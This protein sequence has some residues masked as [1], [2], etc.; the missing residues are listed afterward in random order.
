MIENI[1]RVQDRLQYP[2]SEDGK[3]LLKLVPPSALLVLASVV[4]LADPAKAEVIAQ[5][6]INT[7]DIT[8]IQ[9]IAR[10]VAIPVFTTAGLLAIA[11]FLQECRNRVRYGNYLTVSKVA[12][13]RNCFAYTLFP[14]LVDQKFFGE[15]HFKG[16]WHFRF[17][18]DENEHTV[19]RAAFHDFYKLAKAVENDDPKLLGLN[20]FVALSSMVNPLL[21]RFGFKV[22]YFRDQIGL[23]ALGQE[24]Q[25]Q[26]KLKM[27][28][29][30]ACVIDKK[31]LVQNKEKLAKAAHLP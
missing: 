9:K 11:L 12:P 16:K 26:L 31:T 20:Y 19:M 3:W 2:S 28:P 5:L 25:S 21:E 4:K 14:E 23:P 8:Y 18:P 22:V 27:R 1:R 15:L 30:M 29:V 24:N 13:G 10:G 7:K 6:G 17:S